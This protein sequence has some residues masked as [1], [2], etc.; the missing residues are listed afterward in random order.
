VGGSPWCGG[1]R[2]VWEGH[3]GGINQPEQVSN[4]ELEQ[5]LKRAA[6]KDKRGRN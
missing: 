6:R 3:L 5:R 4:V 2:L 1:V